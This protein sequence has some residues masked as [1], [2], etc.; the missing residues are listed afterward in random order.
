VGQIER[1]PSLAVELVQLRVDVI[2]AGATPGARA[3]SQATRTIPIVAPSMG[4]PVGDGLVASLARPGGNLTGST[5]LGPELVT[6]RV[7]SLRGT[8]D[9]LINETA[10]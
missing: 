2:V 9:E 1:L 4:D 3:A 8:S 10:T 7:E 5:F 6:K